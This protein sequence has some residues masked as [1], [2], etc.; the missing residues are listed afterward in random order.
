MIKLIKQFIKWRKERTKLLAYHAANKE[1]LINDFMDRAAFR[2]LAQ[3]VSN[4]ND[5]V[6][7]LHSVDGTTIVISPK[8]T[9]STTV[10]RP[11][12]NGDE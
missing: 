7:T 1:Y 6:I 8:P 10:R 2:K 5:V 4:N 9:N 11:M 12:I 3:T